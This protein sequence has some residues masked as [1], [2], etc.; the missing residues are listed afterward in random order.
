MRTFSLTP[1][2]FSLQGAGSAVARGDQPGVGARHQRVAHRGQILRHEQQAAGLERLDL[3][4]PR[5]ERGVDGAS[6]PAQGLRRLAGHRRHP[7]GDQRR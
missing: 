2:N 1:F 3:E 6:R 4:L 7:P 5:V